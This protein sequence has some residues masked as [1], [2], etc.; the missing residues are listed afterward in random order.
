[1]NAKEVFVLNFEILKLNYDDR[2]EELVV[3]AKSQVSSVKTFPIYNIEGQKML[4]KP[5]SYTKPLT[6]PFFSYAEVFWSYV[7][8][9]YFDNNIPLYSLAYCQHLTNYISKY[10]S[11]GTVVALQQRKDCQIMNLYDYFM[12]YPDKNV[13]IKDYIN[14][15]GKTYDYVD[16]LQAEVFIK[17]KHLS[18]KLAFSILL[19]ILKLDYNF[20]YENIL[21]YVK[22][23]QIVDLVPMLDHEFSLYFLFPDT[24]QYG[25][26]FQEYI[27]DIMAEKGI[28]YKN[29][30]FIK[31]T[32]PKIYQSFI[33]KVNIFKKDID[34]LH[35]QF[36]KEFIGKFSTHS[37][38]I[39]DARY[40]HHDDKKAKEYEKNM[41]YTDANEYDFDKWN[42]KLI[43][44]L[45]IL[46][47]ILTE[48]DGVFNHY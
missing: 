32:F 3:E 26:C 36:D 46:A 45:K 19:S 4:F 35:I 5:L 10:Y 18:Q 24:N 27:V 44:S 25:K 9:Q 1:M 7:F 43:V 40:K 38:L 47:D 15:C 14:Y 33:K 2:E 34:N 20:H 12:L 8:H 30:A 31:Q 13:H 23:D 21:L 11:Q 42:K 17:N 28:C 22:N 16:I 6:T 29:I 37:W 41:K 48:E 39:G